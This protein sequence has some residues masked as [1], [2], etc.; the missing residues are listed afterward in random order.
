MYSEY[1]ENLTCHLLAHTKEYAH[2]H[3]TLSESG[4]AW[5]TMEMPY[6]HEDDWS[7][8]ERCTQRWT[9]RRVENLWTWGCSNMQRGNWSI[10]DMS[11]K[12]SLRSENWSLITRLLEMTSPGRSVWLSN[13]LKS[14]IDS[15]WPTDAAKEISTITMNGHWVHIK[16]PAEILLHH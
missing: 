13:Q 14:N 16:P 4:G 7:A 9:T 6:I 10:M 11:Q 2:V 5:T 1:D 15:D 8:F 3:L 12:A